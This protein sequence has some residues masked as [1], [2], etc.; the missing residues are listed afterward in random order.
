MF[1]NGETAAL[2]WKY[3]V[4]CCRGP[5]LRDLGI[6]L[7]HETG[8]YENNQVENSYLHFRR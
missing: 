7:K 1:P 6:S 3:D 2:H 5:A 4:K 8:K